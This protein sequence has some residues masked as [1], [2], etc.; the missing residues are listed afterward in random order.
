MANSSATNELL[1]WELKQREDKASA[2]RD[3]MRLIRNFLSVLAVI[4]LTI[5]AATLLATRAG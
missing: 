5:V 2:S 3:N 4:I 1:L